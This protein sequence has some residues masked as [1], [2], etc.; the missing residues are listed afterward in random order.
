MKY[1]DGTVRGQRLSNPKD[2]VTR[3]A[4]GKPCPECKAK[5]TEWCVT[6]SAKTTERLRSRLHFAR[7]QFKPDNERTDS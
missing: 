3:A 6:T 7:C 2:P 5:P 1:G 4:L